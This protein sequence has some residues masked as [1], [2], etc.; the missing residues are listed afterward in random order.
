MALEQEWPTKY[1]QREFRKGGTGVYSKLADLP[2]GGRGKITG[3][4]K[5]YK[6]YKRKLMSMG[7]TPSTMF[8]VVRVAPMGDP[9]EIVIRDYKLS[10]RRDEAMAVPVE[11]L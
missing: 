7:L 9:V 3:F 11:G 2:V 10:L 4:K 8:E 5:G 6:E 1:S